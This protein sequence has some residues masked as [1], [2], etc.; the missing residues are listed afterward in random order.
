MHRAASI[1]GALAIVIAVG[2]SVAE[3]ATPAPASRLRGTIE[4]VSGDTVTILTRDGQHRAVLIGPETKISALRLLTIGDLKPGAYIGTAAMRQVNGH[5]Q[6]L[7]VMV[8]PEALRGVGEGQRPWDLGP[9]SSMT[10]ATVAEVTG[11][12]SG[13]TLQLKYKGGEAELEVTP[14]TPIV[15]PVPG[16]RTLLVA[17]KAVVAFARQ[18]ADGSWTAANFT[19]EKDGVKPPM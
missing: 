19:V 13:R 1:L 4:Q 5:L 8:F 14:E 6:A 9:D 10:N 11:N 16:D 7:E 2:P 15:T 12:A 18:G 17:G 3:T